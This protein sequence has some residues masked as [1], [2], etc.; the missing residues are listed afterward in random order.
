MR[1]PSEQVALEARAAATTSTTDNHRLSARIWPCVR[2]LEGRERRIL[3]DEAPALRA[4]A[5]CTHPSICNE[6]FEVVN[7]AASPSV[8]RP[9]GSQSTSQKIQG[10]SRAIGAYK[11]ARRTSYDGAE[12]RRPAGLQL[13][14]GRSIQLWR[15][16][17]SACLLLRGGLDVESSAIDSGVAVHRNASDVRPVPSH[18][19]TLRIYFR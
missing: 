13:R 5:A 4:R 18:A 2:A 12:W 10:L 8:P 16:V 1:L 3:L 11:C 7:A 6:R 14:R 19:R 9:S 15:V 17:K